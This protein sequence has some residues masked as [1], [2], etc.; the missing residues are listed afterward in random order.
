MSQ[1]NPASPDRPV[2]NQDGHR[3]AMQG[4]SMTNR[5]AE[6]PPLIDGSQ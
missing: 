6:G 1:T 2:F 3:N 5:D 4:S